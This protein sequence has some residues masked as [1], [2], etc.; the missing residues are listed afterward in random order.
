MSSFDRAC[1]CFRVSLVLLFL[2]SARSPALQAQSPGHRYAVIVGIEDYEHENLRTPPLQYSVDDAE[3]LHKVLTAAGYDPVLLTDTTGA[4]DEK[5]IPNKAN[6]EA[7]ITAVLNKCQREDTVILAF[8]GH[9]MQF[10]RQPDA[11]FCPKDARPFK[12][13]TD[14]LVSMTTIYQQLESSFAGVR[15]VLVDACRNDPDPARGR[16]GLNADNAPRPPR[17][18]GALF[19]CS[20]GERSFEHEDLKHGVFF[21][22][23]L[24]G[25]GGKAADRNNQVTF[26]DLSKYVRIEVPKR[27]SSLK[28]GRDQSPNM[29]AD[30]IGVPLLLEIESTLPSES[31]DSRLNR[32]AIAAPPVA[33]F[34]TNAMAIV[35]NAWAKSEGVEAEFTNSVGMKFALIPPGR[36]KMGSPES[37]LG[38][39]GEHEEDEL[40]HE[41]EITRP[42]F[43]GI[44]EVTQEQYEQVMGSNPSYFSESG[45][46]KE[47]VTG[48]DTSS[49]PVEQVSWDDAQEFIRRLNAKAGE[50]QSGRRYRLATEAEWEYACRGGSTGPFSF[51]SSLNGDR[52]N[53]NGTSP[54]GSERKGKYLQRP[55]D[56]GKYSAN[57]FGLY[58]MHGNVWEWCEDLYSADYYQTSPSQDP[59]NSSSS[60]A[61]R[62]ERGGSWFNHASYCRSANRNNI[63]PSMRSEFNGFRVLCR[64][65]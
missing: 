32:P 2:V 53:C 29:K 59:R 34:D 39:K 62:V 56:V 35:R 6:I 3:A 45:G 58:D 48:M 50:K 57:G 23:V 36:F 26:D 8:A 10:E 5:L 24:D 18:V 17:G 60:G 46:G 49:F 7:R 52:A 38:Y 9:G 22:C 51:G 25:L 43:M 21:S 4:K 16:D 65:D 47:Q 11:Y 40:Q 37:E 31:M 30:L 20:A 61:D 41:I 19:S 44:H 63:F 14:S 54:Y 1:F 64:L 42:F 55:C 28:I 27:M 12:A 13:N 15:I 33:P